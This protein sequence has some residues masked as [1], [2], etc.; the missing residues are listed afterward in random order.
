M[1]IYIDGMSANPTNDTHSEPRRKRYYQRVRNDHR[2]IGQTVIEHAIE[3]RTRIR[4]AKANL[5]LTVSR[6]THKVP[7]EKAGGGYMIINAL[8]DP[9]YGVV[10]GQHYAASLA[11]VD[12]FADQLRLRGALLADARRTPQSVQMLIDKALLEQVIHDRAQAI[13]K[14]R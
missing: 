4:L 1:C 5:K 8:G 10:S 11:E 2:R 6:T 13:V 7:G 3:R 14:R 12:R 9:V